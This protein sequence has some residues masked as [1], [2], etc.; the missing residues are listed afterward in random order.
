MP[1]LKR[2]DVVLIPALA[3]GAYAGGRI[4][5]SLVPEAFEKTVAGTIGPIVVEDAILASLRRTVSD[6]VRR[7]QIEEFVSLA[8]R[9]FPWVLHPLTKVDDFERKLCSEFLLNS[10]LIENG[11][12]IRAYEFAEYSGACSPFL[13][14]NS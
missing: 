10:N 1:K 12:D 13:Y 14:A 9:E 7:E 3:A 5:E 6:Q 2:R 4:L 11:Y 8:R